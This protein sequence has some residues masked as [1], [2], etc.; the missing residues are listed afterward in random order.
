MCQRQLHIYRHLF[1]V[2]LGLLAFLTVSIPMPPH[3]D[4]CRTGNSSTSQT[5]W[6]F[7]ALVSTYIDENRVSDL[8][9]VNVW[10]ASQDKFLIVP[11]CDCEALTL[12][13]PSCLRIRT[14]STLMWTWMEFFFLFV[15]KSCL[16]VASFQNLLMNSQWRTQG[17]PSVQ[18]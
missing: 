8:Q 6:S 4:Y 18:Y 1:L 16:L 17:R 10:A 14:I 2:Y 12:S 5:L 13:F 15:T 9:C 11:L 7:E 3:L